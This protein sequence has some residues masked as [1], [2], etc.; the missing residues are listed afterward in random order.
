M[1]ESNNSFTPNTLLDDEKSFVMPLMVIG[2]FFVV[3]LLALGLFMPN[4]N[5]EF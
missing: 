1:E 5:W 3:I 4:T 2:I